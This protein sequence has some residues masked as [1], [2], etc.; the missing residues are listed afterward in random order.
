MSSENTKEPKVEV[1]GE[2]NGYRPPKAAVF[3]E[4]ATTLQDINDAIES[5]CRGKYER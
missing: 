3:N 5:R 2:K 1:N 4:G